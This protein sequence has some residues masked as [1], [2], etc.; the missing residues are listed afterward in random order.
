ME[1]PTPK[2]KTTIT[3]LCIIVLIGLVISFYLFKN[4]Q[5]GAPSV[6]NSGETAHQNLALPSDDDLYGPFKKELVTIE[7]NGDPRIDYLVTQN[8]DRKAV[9][10]EIK[11][12]TGT[13]GIFIGSN[14]R[15]LSSSRVEDNVTGDLYQT[16][17]NTDWIFNPMHQVES[18]LGPGT[19]SNFTY[20]RTATN[21]VTQTNRETLLID[22]NGKQ[23]SYLL[24]TEN[25]VAKPFMNSKELPRFLQDAL[26]AANEDSSVFLDLKHG[27]LITENDKHDSFT[28]YARNGNDWNQFYSHTYG[29]DGNVYML[30]S[31]DQKMLA[32][33]FSTNSTDTDSDQKGNPEQSFIIDLAAKSVKQI[34]T[35]SWKYFPYMWITNDELLYA[36]AGE[37]DCAFDGRAGKAFIHDLSFTPNSYPTKPEDGSWY[38]DYEQGE[39]YDTSVFDENGDHILIKTGPYEIGDF[40]SN[41]AGSQ[42]YRFNADDSKT[43]LY[44]APEHTYIQGIG[45]ISEN[46]YLFVQTAIITALP[47]Q[48]RSGIF[49]ITKIGAKQLKILNKTTGTITD[50]TI[51][52]LENR[53]PKLSDG[54]LQ[55][56][57]SLKWYRFPKLFQGKTPFVDVT[58]EDNFLYKDGQIVDKTE[59]STNDT[60]A[61]PDR[62]IGYTQI[63]KDPYSLE[64]LSD[65]LLEIK[66]ILNSDPTQNG[67]GFVIPGP[68]PSH[69]VS[70][71]Y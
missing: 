47:S 67:I 18:D 50:T 61:N 23:F 29:K 31:P 36:T 53:F 71:L 20:I 56:G 57:F 58:Y 38:Y 2:S 52:D 32:V 69:L 14:I 26:A 55:K 3:A 65:R 59:I 60:L 6:S 37:K 62:H 9:L 4:K 43:V 64:S 33:S 10:D 5:T 39:S 45:S 46:E 11:K 15:I 13:D 24:K 27:I 7:K 66:E 34:P 42:I 40:C 48:S 44:S 1:N 35:D 30:L 25:G 70:L 8:K 12:V 21:T 54:V 63:G 49:D 28:A 41:L 51:T 16:K 17:W 22:E 68:P 19:L